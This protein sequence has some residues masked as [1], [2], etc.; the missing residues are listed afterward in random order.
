[1]S[2]ARWPTAADWLAAGSPS[3]QADLAL[4]GVPT[5]LTSISPT[6]AD[7]TPDA[8]RRHLGRLSTWSTSRQ[9]DLSSLIAADH[10]DVA[11]PDEEVLGEQRVRD[12]AMRAAA[13]VQLL[14]ALGGD[15]SAT[16]PVMA[17]V[18]GDTLTSTAGLVTLDAHHDFR[19][20]PEPGKHSNGTPVRRLVDAVDCNAVMVVVRT[21]AGAASPVARAL[22]EARLPDL[23]GTVAG[24]DTVLVITKTAADARSLARELSAL[25]R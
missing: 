12:S 11:D 21:K 19:E 14:V 22:D 8:V 13:V 4:L 17:G 3:G 16:C 20:G 25:A 9:V 18:C 15:N 24:D 1:V 5:H 10:G 23:L 7:T 6:R 2:D